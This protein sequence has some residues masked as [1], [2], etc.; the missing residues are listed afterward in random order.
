LR[1]WF[2]SNCGFLL[3]ENP[4]ECPRLPCHQSALS[5]QSAAWSH[6]RR[7]AVI[8]AGGCF[9]V[10]RAKLNASKLNAED[11]VILISRMGKIP[12]VGRRAK[13]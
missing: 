10:S 4:A 12:I 11:Y 2:E 9:G 6:L 3:M 13:T 7:D 5:R 8:A 1:H